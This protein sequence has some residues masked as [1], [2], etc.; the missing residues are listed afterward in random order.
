MGIAY[1]YFRTY[2]KFIRVNIER[3]LKRRRY[4]KGGWQRSVFLRNSRNYFV[5]SSQ[6]TSDIVAILWITRHIYILDV[7]CYIWNSAV[8]LYLLQA[9]TTRCEFSTKFIIRK[10]RAKMSVRSIAQQRM[11]IKSISC[12]LVIFELYLGVPAMIVFLSFIVLKAHYAQY[13]DRQDKSSL[14]KSR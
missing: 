8:S 1:N 4:F 7:I 13:F 9:F 2:C 10:S 6:T 12:Y 11:V 5:R 3:R 14:L